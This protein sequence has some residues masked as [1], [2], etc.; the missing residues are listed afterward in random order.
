[1]KM[2]WKKSWVVDMRRTTVVLAGR[3]VILRLR[4]QFWSHIVD[5]WRDAHSLPDLKGQNTLSMRYHR[6]HEA[7]L[8]L[9]TVSWSSPQSVKQKT[10]TCHMSIEACTMLSSWLMSSW[11]RQ[12]QRT[13]D[14]EV[15]TRRWSMWTCQLVLL[16]GL[17]RNQHDGCSWHYS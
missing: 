9:S 13:D 2:L 16:S 11:S 4:P 6:S 1:M 10:W 15:V 14:G 5:H 7:Y 8:P 12:C 3:H 17:T